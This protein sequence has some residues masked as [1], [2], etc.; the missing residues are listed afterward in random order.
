MGGAGDVDGDGYD[1]LIAGAPMTAS[2]T[3]SGKAR[4]YSGFN[5][6]VLY[7]Y[8]G[9]STGDRFGA[10]VSSAGDVNDDG[11]SDVICGAKND[12][13]TAT[14][15]G[16]ASV[17]SGTYGVMNIYGAGCPGSGGFTPILTA[18]GHATPGCQVT[19]RSLRLK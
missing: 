5:G 8:H 6:S 15:A 1:D 16:S 7:T 14:E 17:Y 18:S 11:Y 9:G 3:G 12:S 19:L 2:P 13:N 4:I 10:A